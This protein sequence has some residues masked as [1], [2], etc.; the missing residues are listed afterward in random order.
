M[1]R[2]FGGEIDHLSAF[3][4]NP[5]GMPGYT[6]VAIN[7]R[8]RDGC[9]GSSIGSWDGSFLH[10][11]ESFEIGGTKGFIIV[12]NILDGVRFYPVD[13]PEY[14]CW[15]PTIFHRSDFSITWTNHIKV[16]AEKIFEG[17]PPPITG[18]DGLRSLQIA[19]AAIKSFETGITVKPY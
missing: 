13:D 11:I 4:A 16:F 8:F 14:R 1:L 9:V 6:T 2:H 19:E 3:F 10:D 5:R 15:N 17:L 7:F 18:L 12:D